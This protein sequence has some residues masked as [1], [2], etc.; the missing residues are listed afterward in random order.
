MPIPMTLSEWRAAWLA[1]T[2]WVL[3]P[4]SAIK[5]MMK[6]VRAAVA[7]YVGGLVYGSYRFHW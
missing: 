2:S 1:V 7:D 4:N 3:S 6:A 5:I